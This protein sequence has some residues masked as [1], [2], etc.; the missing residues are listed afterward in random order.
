MTCYNC[1]GL[2]VCVFVCLSVCCIAGPSWFNSG[3]IFFL[4]AS[5]YRGLGNCD[6]G[7]T[8]QNGGKLTISFVGPPTIQT[9]HEESAVLHFI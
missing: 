4:E 7:E 5:G 6:M 3:I 9:V 1:T 2:F 8:E